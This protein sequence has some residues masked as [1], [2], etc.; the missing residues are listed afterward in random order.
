MTSLLHLRTRRGDLTAGQVQPL[1]AQNLSCPICLLSPETLPEEALRLAKTL[2]LPAAYDAHHL[3]LAQLL[4]CELW[5][6]DRRLLR[7]LA[8][9]LSFVHAIGGYVS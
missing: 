5:A 6:N 2:G 8:G 9:K 7:V 3:A 4:A 1:P